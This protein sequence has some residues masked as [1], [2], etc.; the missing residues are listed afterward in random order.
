MFHHLPEVASFLERHIVINV[1]NLPLA[2]VHQDVVEVP[3]AQPDDVPDDGHD[4]K[5][6][7]DVLYQPPPFITGARLEPQLLKGKICCN[8][9][10]G[11]FS[12]SVMLNI[13]L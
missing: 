7:G 3:V 13:Q 8:N 11:I 6:P 5:R 1:D 9:A 4:G 12:H 10:V 2:E